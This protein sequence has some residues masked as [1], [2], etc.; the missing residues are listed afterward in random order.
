METQFQ[1]DLGSRIAGTLSDCDVMSPDSLPSGLQYGTDYT[2][3]Q[4]T[5]RD[6]KLFAAS[7]AASGFSNIILIAGPLIQRAKY[8]ATLSRVSYILEFSYSYLCRPR[9]SREVTCLPRD[10]RFEP[11]W[12]RWIFSERK[13]SEHKSSGEG[14]TLRWG[15]RVWD[16]RIVKEP[17][18][19][20]RRPLSKI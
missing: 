20:K 18:A 9:R 14:G 11:G 7:V 17:Q 3:S 1:F 2:T 4:F 15:S 13:N 10:P 5:Q 8:R 12:G 16:F 6:M 19:W